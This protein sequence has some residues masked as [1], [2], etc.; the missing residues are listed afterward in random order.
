MQGSSSYCTE[1]TEGGRVNL[2]GILN[3]LKPP[4]MTS[5][6]IV[7]RLRRLTGQ[8]K[9]GHSGTL[10][11]GAAGVLPVFL[12]KATRLIEYGVEWD[13]K[14]RVELTL[15]GK[16]E[17]GDDH[18]LVTWEKVHEVPS[19]EKIRQCLSFFIGSQEQIPPMFSALKMNGKKLYELAREGKIVDRK[20]RNI[21]IYSIDLLEYQFPIIRFDVSCSKG[22]YIRTLCEDIAKSLGTCSVMT[23]LLRLEVGVFTISEAYLPKEET[24]WRSLLL[25]METAIEHL[26]KRRLSKQEVVDF[27]QGKKGT[28]LGEDQKYICIQSEENRQLIGIGK[29]EKGLL[30]PVKVLVDI[31]NK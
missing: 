23:F 17:T 16:S 8:R 22:T 10:D 29:I 28:V 26:P 6:D 15:G 20:P 5:H 27:C 1:A 21:T 12:G 25:P 14:Y 11:P 19:K 24:D 7:S 9:I 30:S 2:E 4:G 18:S 13:K 31:R 3:I